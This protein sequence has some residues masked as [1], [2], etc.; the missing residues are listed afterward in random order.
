MIA[1]LHRYASKIEQSAKW[2]VLAS[3]SLAAILVHVYEAKQSVKGESSTP[4]AGSACVEPV[5]LV[6]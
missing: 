4:E 3:P 1:G 6:Q 5:V 2:Q